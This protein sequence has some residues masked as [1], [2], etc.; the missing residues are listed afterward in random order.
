MLSNFTYKQK[1]SAL[2]AFFIFFLIVC[3]QLSISETVEARANYIE[4][5]IQLEEVNNSPELLQQLENQV[6]QLDKLIGNSENVENFQHTLLAKIS[7]YIEDKNI[8]LTSFPEPFNT[9]QKGYELET[10]VFKFES[11]YSDAL[12]LIYYLEEKERLGKMVSADFSVKVNFRNK[13]RDLETTVY[14]QSL[15]S[16]K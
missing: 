14:I 8:K 3:Y 9:P 1:N 13:Q 12:E 6:A 16:V 4:K 7:S 5:A 2:L 10:F 11:N 15:K